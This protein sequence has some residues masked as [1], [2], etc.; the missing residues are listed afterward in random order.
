M[1]SGKK[2]VRRAAA[3]PAIAPEHLVLLFAEGR[4]LADV[5][6]LEGVFAF[7]EGVLA[8][9]EGVLA[10][11]EGVLAL[12]PGARLDV[13]IRG[14]RGPPGRLCPA[15]ESSRKRRIPSGPCFFPRCRPR[16]RYPRGGSAPLS[17]LAALLALS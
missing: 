10:Y 3:E 2:L 14:F 6:H 16:L 12:Y 11:L 7:L 8:Y 15:A 9:L 5:V 17:L 13:S 1:S 4:F